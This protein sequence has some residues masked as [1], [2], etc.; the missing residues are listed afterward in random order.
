MCVWSTFQYHNKAD[1]G[2]VESQV[3]KGAEC[4]FGVHFSTT[5]GR[6][7]DLSLPPI[8]SEYLVARP[9]NPRTASKVETGREMPALFLK[10]Y[11]TR[12]GPVSKNSIN[13]EGF[14]YIMVRVAG[15]R[16]VGFG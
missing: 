7:V 14:Q 12:G 2:S 4:A 10:A 8:T 5:K 9:E 6:M 11:C 16:M 3:V 13:A 1:A 15:A